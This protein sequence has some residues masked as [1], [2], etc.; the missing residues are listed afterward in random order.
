[1]TLS[2]RISV[3]LAITTLA[4]ASAQ[5]ESIL[6]QLPTSPER[7]VST[8]PPNGDENPYGVTVV[9]AGFPKGG[10]LAPGDILVSNFNNNMNVQ[11]T[12]TTIVSIAPGQSASVFFEGQAPL[13]LTTAL[14]VLHPGAVA[15]AREAVA[16]A[17]EAALG[18]AVKPG[19]I[20]DLLFAKPG[21]ARGPGG[22][23]GT[24]GDGHG[25]RQPGAEPRPSVVGK[26]LPLGALVNAPVIGGPAVRTVK[27]SL[28][29]GTNPLIKATS[30]VPPKVAEPLTFIVSNSAGGPVVLLRMT[31]E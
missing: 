28:G 18:A 13:G 3:I 12:G 22:I 26:R 4:F 5:A 24:M 20:D 7:I 14:G 29:C 15:A 8:V 11:G 31:I 23:A 30:S 6:G 21:D 19:E 1:M 17:Q 25:R 9:P 27:L 16:D 2:I 10:L